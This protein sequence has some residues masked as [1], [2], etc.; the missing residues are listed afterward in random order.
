MTRTHPRIVR[1]QE[2]HQR[3]NVARLDAAIGALCRD[4]LG[5]ALGGVPFLL[6]RSLDVARDDGIDANALAA[7]IAR[8]PAR[9]TFDRR[10]ARLVQNQIG[11]RGAS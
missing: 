1:R 9:Q 3:G 10:L 8:E 11:A 6:A 4:D 7:E 2:Q 5:L